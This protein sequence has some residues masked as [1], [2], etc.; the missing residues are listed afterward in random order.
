[1]HKTFFAHRTALARAVSSLGLLLS[2]Q[3]ALGQTV[4]LN[5]AA[6]PLAGALKALAEQSGLQLAFSPEQVQGKRAPAVVGERDPRSALAQMLQ[7]TGL[8]GRIEAGMLT[9]QRLPQAGAETTLAAVTVSAQAE[10]PGTTQGTDSY[11]TWST[12]SATGLALS[13]QETPQSVT[14]VTQQRMQDQS[15]HNLTDVMANTTGISASINDGSRMTYYARGFSVSN[16]QYDGIATTGTS[17]WHAGETELDA[18]LYDRIEVVRGATGLLTGAGNPAASINL[19]RK[20]ADSKVF[21]GEASLAL[22]SWSNKRSMLDVSTP[23]S[24][25]GR[26]RGRLVAAYQDSDSYVRRSHLNKKV[27]YGVVD[28][29]LAPSTTLSIGADYQDNSP[30]G[31]PWGGFPLWYSDGTR[32]DWSRSATPAADWAYWA[33]QTETMF[34]NLEH[35]FD[36]A[37]KANLGYTRSKQSLDTK[38]LFLTGW[39]DASDGTGMKALGSIYNGYREQDS[40]NAQLSG[41]VQWLGRRHELTFGLSSSE[42]KYRYDYQ[43][44]L[45]LAPVVYDE[46]WNGA[47][48]EPQWSASRT[49]DQ[50]KVSQRGLYGAARF[51][52]SERSNLIVGGRYS[53]WRDRNTDYLREDSKFIP[54]AGW[55]YDLGA[56]TTVYASYTSI[57]N[58]QDARD[59]NGRYLDPLMGKNYELGL[60]N[61]WYGGALNTS[62]AVFKI[63]QENLAQADGDFS[64]PGAPDQA[65]YGAKGVRSTGVE[66]EASGSLG[67]GWNMFAGLTHYTAKDAGGT[68]VN[69]NQPRTLLRL[70]TNYRLTGDYSGLSLGGGVNWQS[71]NYT[72]AHGPNGVERVSQGAYALVSLMA[73]YEFNPRTALQINLNN[74]FDKAYYSQ[75]GYYSHGAWGAPRSVMATLSHR[76]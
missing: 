45:N 75:I 19:I 64:V 72:M 70:F 11:T 74:V 30:K 34:A 31:S 56:D 6:Q 52:L 21:T 25:D 43:Q 27:F 40:I 53:S 59:R 2:V 73:R 58:P 66:L 60:K 44:A 23:I 76:F 39:P 62:V 48:P 5:I 3:C 9:V 67:A 61:S 42:Q 22:G 57:F 15:L 13:L 35:R 36:N 14:V 24:A 32:T 54:Y 4:P 20:R 28:A 10:R 55:T 65:Y 49:L 46:H 12:A 26:I 16:F 51:S 7:A 63:A 41:P 18:A 29:D 71:S 69:T 17:N 33:T 1:M 37:W 68:A 47:Y 8:T 50:G 38:L